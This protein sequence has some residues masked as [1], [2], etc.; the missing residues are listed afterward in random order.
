MDYAMPIEFIK[1]YIKERLFI[2]TKL[3]L[4]G[5][6]TSFAAGQSLHNGNK[7]GCRHKEC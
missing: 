1:A 4:I 3:N 6:T 2:E 7:Y 5:F